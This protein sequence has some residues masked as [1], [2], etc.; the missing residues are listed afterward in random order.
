[1]ALTR[2]VSIVV[3][4]PFAQMPPQSRPVVEL[5]TSERRSERTP[6]EALKMPPP[7]LAAEQTVTVVSTRS[8]VPL[9]WRQPPSVALWPS[10]ITISSSVR[11]V[12]GR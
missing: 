4:V 3:D 5:S 10:V 11:C 2:L 6:P 8:S 9:L 12:P 7:S 1:L